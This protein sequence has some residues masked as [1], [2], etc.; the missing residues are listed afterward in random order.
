[1]TARISAG[2]NDVGATYLLPAFAAVFFG[3]TQLQRGRPNVWGTVLAVFV[4][5]AGVKGLELVGAPFWVKNIFN[6]AALI[7]AVGFAMHQRR[8]FGDRQGGRWRR[9]LRR[10][11]TAGEASAT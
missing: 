5:A 8:G 3:S 1:V 11:D 4:L 7:V 2:S 10:R 6:G 9:L